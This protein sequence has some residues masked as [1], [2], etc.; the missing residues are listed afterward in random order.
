MGKYDD[1]IDLKHPN[2]HHKRMS[3][4][5]RAAQFASF[6]A[7]TGH[8]ELLENTAAEN[9]KSIN[10]KDLSWHLLPDADDFV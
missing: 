6:A 1:I 2:L 4:L 8:E 9:E 7:L 3:T 10:D 5:D